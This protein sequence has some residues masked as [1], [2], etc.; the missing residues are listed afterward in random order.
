M[1][2]N[3]KEAFALLNNRVDVISNENMVLKVLIQALLASH[4]DHKKLAA[5]IDQKNEIFV[6]KAIASNLSDETINAVRIELDRALRFALG[7]APSG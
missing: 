1:D 4:H 5:S 7:R 6:A 2:K 3:E